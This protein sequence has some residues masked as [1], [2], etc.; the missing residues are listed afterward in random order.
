MHYK[1]CVIPD[2]LSGPNVILL[3]TFYSLETFQFSHKLKQLKL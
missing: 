1:N 2:D 3:N